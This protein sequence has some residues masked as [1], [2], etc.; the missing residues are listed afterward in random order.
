MYIAKTNAQQVEAGMYQ[1]KWWIGQYRHAMPYPRDNVYRRLRM[2]M[3]LTQRR[4]AALFGISEQAWR[5]RERMK[6]MYHVA[7]I[8]ALFDAS[9]MS[10]KDFF[11]LLNECA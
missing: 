1:G 11:K 2:E 7:E 8:L 6:R 5:Y 3:K 4:A 10:H 9:G